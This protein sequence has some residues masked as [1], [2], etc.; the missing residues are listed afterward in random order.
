MIGNGSH[1]GDST[2]IDVLDNITIVLEVALGPNC[3]LYTHD[4]D[5]QTDH[6]ADWKGALRLGEIHVEDGAWIDSSVI[7]LPNV[8][9]GK[10]PIVAAGSVVRQDVPSR[11][12]VGEVPAK[13]L[14]NT[15]TKC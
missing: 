11:V 4:H 6:E 10:R 3:T 12:I 5:F 13:I 14:K 2:I 15:L 8:K 7:F 9:V 1:I